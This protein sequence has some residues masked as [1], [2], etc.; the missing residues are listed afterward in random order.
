MRT[1]VFTVSR[2]KKEAV[3]F[4]T[5]GGD[6]HPCDPDTFVKAAKE[7]LAGLDDTSAGIELVGPEGMRDGVFHRL[8]LSYHSAELRRLYANNLFIAGYYGL[9]LA[10]DI[11]DAV[12]ANEERKEAARVW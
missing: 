5:F 11:E 8:R 3:V 10:A 4:Y 9:L 6:G 12:D 1:P 7:F 2:T